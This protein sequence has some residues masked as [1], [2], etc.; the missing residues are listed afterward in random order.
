MILNSCSVFLFLCSIGTV[1]AM[2][3]F[4]GQIS[5]EMLYPFCKSMLLLHIQTYWIA[6]LLMWIVFIIK[7]HAVYKG[8][9]YQYSKRLLQGV[10]VVLT[11]HTL[12]VLSVFTFD[13]K[14]EPNEDYS[15]CTVEVSLYLIGIGMLSEII[16][17][18][19]GL[20]A[21][22]RPL[23][24]LSTA[25][26]ENVKRASVSTSSVHGGHSNTYFMKV[27][28]KLM[29]LNSMAC[30]STL[31]SLLYAII[32]SGSGLLARIDLVINCCCLML[33]T[34]YYPDK[35]YQSICCCMIRC[36]YKVLSIDDVDYDDVNS[37]E[38]SMT[39]P[40]LSGQ[41]SLGGISTDS[42]GNGTNEMTDI[43]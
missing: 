6:K 24:L 29:V 14:V 42:N 21:F 23:K 34:L 28:A 39:A 5:R 19:V 10:A 20:Y 15:D 12:F 2:D 43:V 33:M 22:V 4:V 36:C 38:R 35:H 25:M 11:I 3:L 27:G 41:R 32:L 9:T 8:S 18:I 30:I 37:N 1:A 17:N 31:M 40:Q 7:L 13:Q 16:L 26:A